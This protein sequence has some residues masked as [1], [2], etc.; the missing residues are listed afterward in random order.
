PA[1][2]LDQVGQDVPG[3][4]RGAPRV[5]EPGSILTHP[6]ETPELGLERHRG[7]GEHLGTDPGQTRPEHPRRNATTASLPPWRPASTTGTGARPRR[8]G[9][10]PRGTVSA[11]RLPPR[12]LSPLPSPGVGREPGPLTRPAPGRYASSAGTEAPLRP[13]QRARRAPRA[14]RRA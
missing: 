12:M 9:S 7:Q 4:F 11:R 1:P 5:G 14:G 13:L 10:V 3:L 2:H 8:E 6:G